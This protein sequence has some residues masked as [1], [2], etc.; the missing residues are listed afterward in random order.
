MC[1]DREEVWNVYCE[2]IYCVESSC[3]RRLPCFV[4]GDLVS[5]V[6]HLVLDMA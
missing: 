6:A 5:T 1:N 4:G 3:R 2:G